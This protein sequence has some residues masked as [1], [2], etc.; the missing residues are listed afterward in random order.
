MGALETT[1]IGGAAAV[2][3]WFAW[4]RLHEWSAEG[5]GAGHVIART[6]TT[7]SSQLGRATELTG[8]VA[9]GAIRT[10]GELVAKGVGL[11]VS[12]A[13]TVANKVVPGRAPTTSKPAA[14]GAPVTTTAT[15]ETPT[16]KTAAKKTA[17]K[18]TV[19][20]KTVAKK[21]VAKPAA[22]PKTV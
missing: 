11:T 3:G 17:A 12:T 8:V 20:K 5:A 15:K 6:G 19:A 14:D 18:K 7:V 1:L 22:T 9:G 10:S 13:G 16:K 4:K 21:T 2:G